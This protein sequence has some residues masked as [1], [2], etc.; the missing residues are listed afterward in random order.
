MCRKYGGRY[1]VAALIVCEK[2]TGK[3]G[4]KLGCHP[5]IGIAMER[6]LTEATQGQDIFEYAKRSIIDFKNGDVDKWKNIY[7]SYKFGM[8]KYPYQLFSSKSDYEFTPVKD[9]SNMSNSQILKEWISDIL[10]TGS[11]IYIRDVSFLGFPSFHIIIPGM[12]EMI[13]PDDTKFRATN[14]R[15]HVSNLLRD[16]PEE[17]N[18]DNCRYILQP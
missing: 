17:I 9:V 8:G 16:S 15:Y 3:F 11:D 1:P 12:S 18:K 13:Y 4:I 10:E 6:T 14:T 2:N 7:N 5:D